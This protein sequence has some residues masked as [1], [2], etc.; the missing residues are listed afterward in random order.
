RGRPA[1]SPPVARA[2]ANLRRAVA[3]LP[4]PGPD[5]HL[6]DLLEPRGDA[7]RVG[8]RART[9]G[10]D[11]PELPRVGDRAPARHARLDGALVVARASVRLVEPARLEHRL[12]LRPDWHSR[13]PRRRARLGEEA[14]RR[15]RV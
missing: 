11:L 15:A 13:S 4:P 10:L 2:A 12:D 3:R 7:G 14:P 5:R 1:R 6:R 8:L 9:R